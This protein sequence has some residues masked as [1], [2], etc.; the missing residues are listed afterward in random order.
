M[1]HTDVSLPFYVVN[2]FTTDPFRG[3]PAAVV[4]VD[5]LNNSDLLHNIAINFAQP[6]TAFLRRVTAINGDDDDDG[7]SA[8]FE[9]RWFTTG[10]ELPL[11]GHAT[12][13]SSG[14]M[15]FKFLLY[16]AYS[17]C[18]RITLAKCSGLTIDLSARARASAT[19]RGL[20]ICRPLR[21][22]DS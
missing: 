11:C 18:K 1:A 16:F 9:V 10:G 5:S 19:R 20:R 2:A 13:A 4:F 8:T 3:N 7:K 12:I 14:L 6:M 21:L 22:S 15:F 17:L